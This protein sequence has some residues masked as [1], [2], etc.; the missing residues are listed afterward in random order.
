MVPLNLHRTLNSPVHDFPLPLH[1]PAIRVLR[2]QGTQRILPQEAF[3]PQS[4]PRLEALVAHSPPQN[5]H[6]GAS[7]TEQ[8]LWLTRNFTVSHG[9]V[10]WR[11]I[12]PIS[13]KMLEHNAIENCT[14]NS[15]KVIKLPLPKLTSR[16][17][18]FLYIECCR[19][20]KKK[21]EQLTLFFIKLSCELDCVCF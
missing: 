15:L 7:E 18:L 10:P 21:F 8:A 1:S 3:S 9:I 4:W 16:F 17:V 11:N 6:L 14:T 12:F 13:K 19:A 20:K 2:P 5:A